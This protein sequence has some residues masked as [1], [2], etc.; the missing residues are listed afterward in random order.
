MA[1]PCFRE[2]KI[3]R[4]EQDVVNINDRLNR[5]SEKIDKNNDNTLVLETILKRLEED[6]K[7]QKQ[8]N[9]EMNRT[10]LS[11]QGAMTE[12]T[13]NIRELNTSLSET[14]KKVD[15]TSA[16]VENVNSKFKVDIWEVIKVKVVP[17]LFGGGII[18]G[19]IALINLLAK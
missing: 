19:V 11:I 10:M 15:A 16:K 9:T 8:T 4:L 1:E 14:N 13:F 18:G 2:D 3:N 5:H 6:S 7:E 17:F 12:I